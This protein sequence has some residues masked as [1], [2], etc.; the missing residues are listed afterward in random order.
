MPFDRVVGI[1]GI[2][3]AVILLVLDKAGKLKGGWLI[4]LLALAGAMTLFIAIGNSWVLEAPGKWKLWRGS[5]M[6]F[7]VLFIYSGLSIWIS[8]SPSSASQPDEQPAQPAPD[9]NDHPSPTE[10]TTNP[11]SV[12]PIPPNKP[13]APREHHR[14]TDELNVTNWTGVFETSQRDANGVGS[15]FLIWP[16]SPQEFPAT[17]EVLFKFD[18]LAN[19]EPRFEAINGGSA[20][21]DSDSVAA[22]GLTFRITS[23]RLDKNGPLRIRIYSTTETNIVSIIVK[24]EAIPPLAS[25]KIASQK[26]IASADSQLPYGLEVILTTSR[27]ISPTALTIKF[28]GEVGKMYGHPSGTQF[29]EAQGGIIAQSPDTILIQWQ[30]PAFSVA[31]PVVLTVFSKNYIQAKKIESVPFNFP[32]P[33]QLK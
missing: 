12:K 22:N 16:E 1:G 11:P 3:L 14:T 13:V 17:I 29:T 32:Y 31:E 26:Q 30:T 23:G 25:I 33:G 9:S 2:V 10:P 21:I 15:S 7:L 8:E 19:P 5:L 27:D 28:S 4:G 24:R 20:D 18:V 6:L